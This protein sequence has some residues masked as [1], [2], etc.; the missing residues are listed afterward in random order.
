MSKSNQK[1]SKQSLFKLLKQNEN[2]VSMLEK[3]LEMLRH[4]LKGYRTLTSLVDHYI[5]YYNVIQLQN[6]I[7]SYDNLLESR[8]AFP[9]IIKKYAVRYVLIE[10]WLD[11]YYAAITELKLKQ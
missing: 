9:E 2:M 3:E 6:S 1:E 7:G 11:E 4:V 5:N 8:E 10:N